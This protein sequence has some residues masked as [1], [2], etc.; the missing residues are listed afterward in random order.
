MSEGA[1]RRVRLGSWGQVVC[2]ESGLCSHGKD[3]IGEHR[4]GNA[5]RRSLGGLWYVPVWYGKEWKGGEH[6]NKKKTKLVTKREEYAV[7]LKE[8]ETE[9]GVLTPQM[10][11][12]SA[13]KGGSPLHDIFDWDDSSAAKKYRLVQARMLINSVQ[14]EIL[15]R[16]TE[17]YINAVVSIESGQRGYIATDVAMNDAFIYAQV[18]KNAAREMRYWQNK[19]KNLS[20]LEGVV[21][22]EKLEQV[23]DKLV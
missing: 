22:E 23:E 11:V 3:E 13:A 1:K 18:L 4:W 17:G 9:S 6:M 21:N 14:I 2:G 19:Y 7:V 5:R 20:D 12:E 16:K 15:G 8:L 10:V